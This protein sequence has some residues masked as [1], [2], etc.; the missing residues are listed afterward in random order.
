M[1]RVFPGRGQQ[2]N[3]LWR[4]NQL[5]AQQYNWLRSLIAHYK[6]FDEPNEHAL[7]LPAILSNS[8]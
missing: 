4:T 5:Q 1:R 3:P 8:P 6:D 2:E 7:W